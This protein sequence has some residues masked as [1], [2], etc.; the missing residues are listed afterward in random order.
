M[1]EKKLYLLDALALIFRA[2]FAFISNPRYNSKG[3][4]TS[5][6]F[7]FT[8]SL[9]E[10]LNKEKPTHIGVAFDT[11]HPTF[12]HERFPEY[13]ANREEAP[14]DV[15]AAI[16]LT[17][18][19]L[20]ALK[21]PVLEMPGYEA[22]DIIGTIAHKAADHGF[23]VYMVTPDKD[24]A[25]LVTDKVY[26]YKPARQGNGSE[27]LDVD[28]VKEK[29]GVPP[30]RVVDF[31]GLK[32]DTVDNIPGI[33]RVGDKTAVSLINEF[34][35]VEDIIKNAENISKKSIKASVQEFGEQGILSKELATIMTDVPVKWDENDLEVCPPDKERL[36]E[37]LNELEFRTTAKRILS[38]P[39]FGNQ[40]VQTDLFGNVEAVSN[41]SEPITELGAYQSLDD[42]GAEYKEVDNEQAASDLIREIKASGSFC[43]DTE[44]T[45]LDAIRAELVALTI[46][47]KT[48]E[49]F[50]V[51][52]P[53]DQEESQRRLNWFREIFEDDSIEKVGQNLKYDILVLKN[54]GVSVKGPIFDTMLADYLVNS[55]RSHSMDAMARDYLNYE[56]ISITT[57]IGKKGKNQLSMRQVDKEKLVKYACEDSDIT[58]ELKEYLNP[59]LDEFGAREVFNNIEVPLVPVLFEMEYA[60]VKLDEDA[61]LMY[62]KELGVEIEKTERNI[63]ELA[64]V[65]FNIRSPK[66]LGEVLFDKLQIA[67]GKKTKTGQYKTS[68]DILVQLAEVHELPALVL[69]FRKLSKLKSTYVDVLPTLINPDTGRVHTTFSQAVAATGRLSS[70]HP[71]LQNIPIRSEEGREIRKAFVPEDGFV[72]MSA[73]Y[74]QVEL[75][76]MAHL[77]EDANMIEAFKEGMDIHTATA[78]RVFGVLPEEVDGNMRSKAKMVNFGII[79]GISAFGL[80]QRLKISRTEAREIIDTYFE[81]Y[82]AVKAY[83]DRSIEKAR[84]NG[85]A[86]T[87]MGRRRILKDINSKNA[88]VRGFAERN[89][90]NAP[91]QGSAA[92]LI[93]LAMIR[94]H[95]A[96]KKQK[97]ESRMILQVHDELVFEA[98]ESELEALK[99][100]VK[101]K[102]ENALSLKVPMK[103]EAGIG[104][105]WLEAH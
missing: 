28:K 35:S 20:E 33:P 104:K 64:G 14:E 13:K 7:G 57:L 68:E 50:V 31:L 41:S 49:G 87:I 15:R 11:S 29:F 8:N 98:K 47:I 52:F 103:V 101:D 61:L 17:K 88:T 89:A 76:I 86:E 72:L 1:S 60:G 5:A 39:L 94:I 34:G 79:Y 95:E 19:L 78:A 27:I 69:H 56:P 67:K 23:D 2:H 102:M 40:T 54:Y 70:N 81:K 63:Y 42:R 83:M 46:S 84:E 92:D 45:S 105:N 59:K 65:E 48:K 58:L 97:L 10:I 37:L 66:Q 38:S 3:I 99:E 16:P 51:L 4:N 6:I 9:L 32:G 36:I 85:Y 44:T 25:Q 75:R 80:A 62:S 73:D 24:Y 55:E 26:M 100:L 30:E 82:P 91:V 93:K 53:E 22:D 90:I 21:I 43:F 77:S 71:N 12:R 96:M 74:S 18:K